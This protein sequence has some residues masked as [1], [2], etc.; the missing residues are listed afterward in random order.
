MSLKAWLDP[1]AQLLRAEEDL[2]RENFRNRDSLS[3]NQTTG[4]AEEEE[5]N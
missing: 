2:A 1:G 5:A 3:D 4:M